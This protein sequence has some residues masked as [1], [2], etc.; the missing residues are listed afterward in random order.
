M[1]PVPSREPQTVASTDNSVTEPE[2]KD[3]F[4]VLYV[5]E[6]TAAALENIG[7]GSCI[8]LAGFREVST[9]TQV[10]VL[11]AEGT[12]LAFDE[13]ASGNSFVKERDTYWCQ[14]LFWLSDVPQGL[15]VYEIRVGNLLRD[16]FAF[17]EDELFAAG[18]RHLC[19]G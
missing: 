7:D 4:G 19:L 3:V 6:D 9:G 2:T 17:A 15:G 1:G 18:E 10:K 12:I 11:D 16:G 14:F 8:P 5:A 13:L